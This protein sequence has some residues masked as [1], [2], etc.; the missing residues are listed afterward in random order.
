MH[1]LDKARE[2]THTLGYGY[3]TDAIYILH[4]IMVKLLFSLA[5]PLLAL[6]DQ[7]AVLEDLAARGILSA[8]VCPGIYDPL[9]DTRTN[10]CGDPGSFCCD[11]SGNV[12]YM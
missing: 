6:G 4:S 2:D 11:A 9:A 5:I 12:N 1:T 8:T 3:D 10:N 7:R